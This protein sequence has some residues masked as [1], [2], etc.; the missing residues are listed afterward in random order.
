MKFLIDNNNI[1]DAIEGNFASNDLQ[2]QSL[3]D[4]I[5][6]LKNLNTEKIKNITE[7]NYQIA[8]KELDIIENVY[9]IEE[10]PNIENYEMKLIELIDIQSEDLKIQRSKYMETCNEL[11]KEL[12][13]RKSITGDAEKII[14]EQARTIESQEKRNAELF[15]ELNSVYNSKRFKLVNK[16]ANTFNRKK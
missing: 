1:Y 4:I 6:Q 12:E 13:H 15:N 5:D 16:I 2:A 9:C 7:E 3:K 10:N 14:E 11:S 8:L